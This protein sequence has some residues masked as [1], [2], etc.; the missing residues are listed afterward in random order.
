MKAIEILDH[1]K[2]VGTW[3]IWNGRENDRILFGDPD[4]E[5][6]GIAV[7]WMPSMPNLLQAK[8]K[9]C[10]VFITHEPLYMGVANQF[11]VYSADGILLEENDPWIYKARWLEREKMVVIR[12]HDTWDD[13]PGIGI[14]GAWAKWLGFTGKPA[15]QIKFY[16]VHEIG[17]GTFGALCEHVRKQAWSLGQDVVLAIG[18][19]SKP[20]SKVAIGTGAITNYRIM[21][22]LGADVII[23]TDDGTRLWESAQWAEDADV[24]II[25]VNHA[26]A[27]EP[28]MRTLA[29][30]LQ[31]TF[32]RVPV[33][34]IE[35]G[36][37]YRAITR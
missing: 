34:E 5:V 4:A 29:R 32:P 12:C 28:G 33:H 21:Y 7:A 26:T 9:G 2:K 11:G 25:V 14:H 6:R 16:E 22:N 23:L 1:F 10:N 37:L 27:E 8:D 35:R 18:D 19:E 36:C 30:Y 13:F 20:V 15:V 31:D 17:A 24:P 3:V